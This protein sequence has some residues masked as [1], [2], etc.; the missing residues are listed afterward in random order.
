MILWCWWWRWYIYCILLII[1]NKNSLL[2]D[3]ARKTIKPKINIYF[4]NEKRI[5]FVIRWLRQRTNGRTDESLRRHWNKFF[6]ND[7]KIFIF[8]HFQIRTLLF[9]YFSYLIW[10][11]YVSLEFQQKK[12]HSF[13]LVY[14]YS[15]H[16]YLTR[17]RSFTFDVNIVFVLT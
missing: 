16:F 13:S 6:F 1:I 5:T 8:K 10:S 2:V 9:V 14:I 3:T 11:S 17:A 12:K 15:L 7:T 4:N